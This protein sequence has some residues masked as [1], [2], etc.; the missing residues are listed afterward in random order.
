MDEPFSGLDS[1]LKDSIRADTLA[2]L[3]ET[4]ATAIVVTHDAEEAMR[5]GDRI[6]LL[7]DGRL[8]QHGSADA[9]YRQPKSLFAAGFFS[10]INEFHGVV[11]GG[12]VET[13]L[14]IV[15]APGMGEGA[16]VSAAVRLSSVNVGETGGSIPA[17]ILS[18]RFLGVVE[19]LNFAVPG[20]ETPVRAR[21]RADVL[22]QGLREVTLS[23]DERDIL[24]FEKANGSA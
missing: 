1:R 7:K 5:M 11:R 9:L 17:R 3:R 12:R 16:P 14:G 8:I 4:R 10:E 21:I 15:A 2:I 24:L 6:A 20:S 22:P 23:V 18:R 13:P 19:L